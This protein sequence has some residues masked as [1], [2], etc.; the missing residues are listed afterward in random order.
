MYFK[1][2]MIYRLDFSQGEPL[3]TDFECAEHLDDALNKRPFVPCGSHDY[4]TRGWVSPAGEGLVATAG[5]FWMVCLQTEQKLIPTSYVN[6]VAQERARELEE[7]QGFKL[8]RKQMK[9]L[10]EQVAHELLPRAFTVRSKTYA[11]FDTIMDRL[12]IDASSPSKAEAMIQALRDTLDVF[13][14]APIR[15]M[16]SPVSAMADWLA[17]EEGPGGF[18]ID[19]DFSLRSPTEDRAEASFKRHDLSAAHVADHLKSGKLPTKVAMTYADR[20]SFVLTERLELRRIDLLDVVRD[21][22][23]DDAEDEA[24]LF[25]AEFFLMGEELRALITN[26]IAAHGGEM[27]SIDQSNS[28]AVESAV[29]AFKEAMEGDGV[30]HILSLQNALNPSSDDEENPAYEAAK[31]IVIASQSASISLLQRHLLFGYNR[32]ARLIEQMEKDGIVSPMG[33]DGTRKVLAQTEAG[34]TS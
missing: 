12:I 9:D 29:G 1:N 3:P 8:G 20:V 33:I 30:A 6:Q 23:A 27:K 21:T 7:L 25:R 32:S 4:E 24:A 15:T 16:Q 17:A 2:A 28:T 13:P 34:A 22:I 31:K 5:N 18:T 19:Q 11:Y 26:L 14:V 10:R